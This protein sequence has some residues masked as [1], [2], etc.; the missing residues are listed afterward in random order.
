MQNDAILQNV[1]DSLCL[2][3]LGRY[4]TLQGTLSLHGLLLQFVSFEHEDHI[5][6]VRILNQSCLTW[7]ISNSQTITE[8]LTLEKLA[9]MKTNSPFQITFSAKVNF[10]F[11]NFFKKT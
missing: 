4:V 7:H 6:T 5:F 2:L 10:I 9:H 3:S 8:V 1:S 11:I